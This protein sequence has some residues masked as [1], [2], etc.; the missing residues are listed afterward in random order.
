MK[1]RKR[2]VVTNPYKNKQQTTTEFDAAFRRGT[3]LLHQNNPQE[4]L[5]HLEQ[6]CKLDATHVD[7]AINLSGAYILTKKFAQALAIL[8]PLTE[9]APENTMVW[10]NLGAAHLGNPVLARD[11]EQIKAIAA[12]EKALD[13]NPAA[14][15]VAY[16]LGLIYRDRKDTEQAIYWFRRAIQANPQDRDARS[17]LEKLTMNNEQ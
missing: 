15:S 13:L 16:N 14:P 8:E 10:I 7:A 11:A 6:A 3:E 5:P 17:L 4:A 12:F 9:T 1:A 2:K